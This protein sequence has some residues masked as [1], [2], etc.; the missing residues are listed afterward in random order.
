MLNT[1]HAIAFKSVSIGTTVTTLDP[2]TNAVRAVMTVETASLRYRYD[3]GGPT[4][5]V[6]HLMSPGDVLVIEGKQ[7]LT[8]FAATRSGSTNAV[9]SITFEAQ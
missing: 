6:G 7:N 9:L 8:Q 3:G 4:S 2:P 1:E 5:G